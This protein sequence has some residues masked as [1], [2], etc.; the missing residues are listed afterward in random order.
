MLLQK[1]VEQ[2]RVHRV[3]ANVYGFPSLS[4]QHQCWIHL[5]DFF[6]NQTEL[7]RAFVRI[8]LVMESDRS[9]DRIASLVFAM[10]GMSFLNRSEEVYRTQLPVWDT[11]TGAVVKL[12]VATSI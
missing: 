4:R 6:G 10:L 5:R 8:R 1:L 9:S 11:I 2:H 7:R 12:C 3:V